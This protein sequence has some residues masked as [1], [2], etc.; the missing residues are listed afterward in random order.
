MKRSGAVTLL[1]ALAQDSRLGIFML[2]AGRGSAGMTVGTIGRRLSF[3]ATT[4]SFH[5]KEL[6]AAKLVKARK[7]GRHVYYA[8]D[9]KTMAALIEYLTLKGATR[10]P[11]A[12]RALS[13]ERCPDQQIHT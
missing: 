2:L 8:A 12:G 5:L 10:I 11:H 9:F 3:S 1:S 6:R 7:D 13:R 4:L